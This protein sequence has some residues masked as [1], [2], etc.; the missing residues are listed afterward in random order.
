M[1][2]RD[3]HDL[4]GILNQNKDE[5]K[6]KLEKLYQTEFEEGILTIFQDTESVFINKILP[7]IKLAL[8]EITPKVDEKLYGDL[9][10]IL[11]EKLFDKYYQT[12]KLLLKYFNEFKKSQNYKSTE[13]FFR[14]HCN[15]CPEVAIHLCKNRLILIKENN[16]PK[17]LICSECKEV[18]HA[19]SLILY[20]T[21]CD[22]QYYS[23]VVNTFEETE[24]QPATWENY[25]CGSIR[26]NQ[27]R[28]IKCKD[29][30]FIRNSDNF[31]C[32]IKC[33]FTSDQ[34]KLVWICTVCK[35][36]FQSNAKIYNSIEFLI[37]KNCIKEAILA[38]VLAKPSY[39]PCCVS[40]KLNLN[41]FKHKKQCQGD[42]YFG[43]LSG[44]CILVCNKCKCVNNFEG[45]LWTCPKCDGT[46]KS[47]RRQDSKKFGTSINF[48][49]NISNLN[50]PIKNKIN[51]IGEK[52][53]SGQNVK[54]SVITLEKININNE[55][56]NE[57]NERNNVK[58]REEDYKKQDPYKRNHSVYKY[59]NLNS[60]LDSNINNIKKISSLISI[61]E[62]DLDKEKKYD[63]KLTFEDQ[64]TTPEKSSLQIEKKTIIGKLESQKKMQNDQKFNIAINYVSRNN[65]S[66]STDH[67]HL[68]PIKSNASKPIV[69]VFKNKLI[70]MHTTNNVKDTSFDIEKEPIGVS[71]KKLICLKSKNVFYTPE[72]HGVKNN[73][74]GSRINASIYDSEITKDRENFKKN[75]TPIVVQSSLFLNYKN[76]IS[77]NSGKDVKK[78][79]MSLNAKTPVK[80]LYFD[81]K[82]HT[83]EQENLKVTP[84]MTI[85]VDDYRIKQ[86]IGEGSF[87]IIYSAENIMTKEKFA[88]KKI[89]LNSDED[90]NLF[91]SEFELVNK[92]PHKN[93]VTIY[94]LCNKTL[95]FST[96][97]LYILMELAISDWDKE[98]KN[99]L[100]LNSFYKEQDL[101]NLLKQ[102][103]LSLSFLQEKGI[104]HRDIKPQNVLIFAN[105]S[106]KIAD[107]G[108]AKEVKQANKQMETL[109]GTELYMS[110]I[111][112]TTLRNSQNNNVIHNAFKSD[113]FSLGYCI[114]YAATLSFKVLYDLRNV[115]NQKYVINIIKTY[116]SKKY[117]V[118]FVEFVSK[119]VDVNESSRFDFIELNKYLKENF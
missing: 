40:D 103:V 94:G 99:R 96:K 86:N 14:K 88:M 113:V 41:N 47:G 33:K 92:F 102:I 27:M 37:L 1:R 15:K 118:K 114:L 60:D 59:S 87:G 42:L 83:I 69:N 107:F 57:R 54:Q 44:K 25:H 24:Y 56:L 112:F 32:C 79:E 61:K 34:R 119:M 100:K 64:E 106:Y 58:S 43:D 73:D 71:G 110:P 46:F 29:L 117:S 62:E 75:S 109:R 82:N 35:N 23:S 51:P 63:E 105:N 21:S 115:T 95:D 108:E 18:F 45:F 89:I 3:N 52:N 72:I 67:N 38:K 10:K 30:L 39:I 26:N 84:L 4:T 116:L 22:T 80:K 19:N 90:I 111:L 9:L 68:S 31:L 48:K 76:K 17:Y 78:I 81:E 70:H 91:K 13:F 8:S 85:N 6:L 77:C 65:E 20:C 93:I 49:E 50:T 28:C 7:R 98:I 66:E 55:E 11:D 53:Y 5:Y 2:G 97:V 104:S 16:D 12:K 101:I 36:E 74:S